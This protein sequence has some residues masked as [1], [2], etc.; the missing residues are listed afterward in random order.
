[1]VVHGISCQ[2]IESR[3]LPYPL[4][5]AA[6]ILPVLVIQFRGFSHYRKNRSELN[7]KVL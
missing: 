1:M 2:V 4:L 7:R 3:K 6:L 5:L